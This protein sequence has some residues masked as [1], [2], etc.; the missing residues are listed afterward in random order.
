MNKEVPPVN[1]ILYKLLLLANLANESGE[2]G[3]LVIDTLTFDPSLS[4]SDEIK[5]QDWK[6]GVNTETITSNQSFSFSARVMSIQKVLVRHEAF[7]VEIL[8]ESPDMEIMSELRNALRA[9]NPQH[10]EVLSSL[11]NNPEEKQC[12]ANEQEDELDEDDIEPDYYYSSDTNDPF[13]DVDS[14]DGVDW[15][16]P[17]TF[18]QAAW[19]QIRD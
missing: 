16:D 19:D 3:L 4:V 6:V 12:D 14:F 9:R 5:I 1:N 8:L 18:N 17:S 13:D 10:L 11:P 2:G 7:I 15:G